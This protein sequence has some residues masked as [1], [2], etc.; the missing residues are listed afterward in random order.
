LPP[1][2]FFLVSSVFHHTPGASTTSFQS[3]LSKPSSSS[4]SYNLRSRT[5]STNLVSEMPGS[6]ADDSAASTAQPSELATITTALAEVQRQLGLFA[7]QMSSCIAAVESTPG[8]SGM[9]PPPDCPYGMPGYGGL[10][11]SMTAADGSLPPPPTTIS[12]PAHTTTSL[13]LHVL[14]LPHSPSP[15]PSL[16]PSHTP[17]RPP[18]PFPYYRTPYQCSLH[19]HMLVFFVSTAWSLQPLMARKTPCTG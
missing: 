4:H 13:P 1:I 9:A 2:V 16:P 10:P 14:P 3:R 18:H 19:R 17:L 7:T 11:P 5:K 12:A 6:N 8:T 15:I